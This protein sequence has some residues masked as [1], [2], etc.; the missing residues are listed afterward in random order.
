M[1]SSTAGTPFSFAASARAMAPYAQACRERPVT[2]MA[3]IKAREQLAGAGRRCDF[4]RS[5]F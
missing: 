1:K 3:G 2:A 4:D 5:H